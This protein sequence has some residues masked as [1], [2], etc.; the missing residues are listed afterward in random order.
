MVAGSLLRIAIVEYPIQQA[1]R[2]HFSLKQSRLSLTMKVLVIRRKKEHRTQ[3]WM[4]FQ[5][6]W[7]AMVT[8]TSI[9]LV[10]SFADQFM[11][12]YVPLKRQ[13]LGE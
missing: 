1:A 7:L 4:A 10:H 2:R 13:F 3:T 8:F 6:N 9:A 5:P 11:W 12:K